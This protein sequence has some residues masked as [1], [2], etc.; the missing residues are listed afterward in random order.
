MGRLS[1]DAA[2]GSLQPEL[3][4]LLADDFTAD[5]VADVKK[6]RSHLR[7]IMKKGGHKLTHGKRLRLHND[8]D[9]YDVHILCERLDEDAQQPCTVVLFVLTVPNFAN[10]HHSSP[11]LAAGTNCTRTA[12][13][14]HL[15]PQLHCTQPA[16]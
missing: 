11:Q 7:A 4:A 3:H 9:G 14:Q 8:D 15:Q 13:T 10:V 5:A 2:S 16:C 12:H 1:V 6:A